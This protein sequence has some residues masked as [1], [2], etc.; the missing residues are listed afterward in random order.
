M[1]V[2]MAGNSPSRPASRFYSGQVKDRRKL[3]EAL[4]WLFA[5]KGYKIGG[6]KLLSFG[7]DF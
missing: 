7:V 4:I 2:G 5:F 1:L 3:D 6:H